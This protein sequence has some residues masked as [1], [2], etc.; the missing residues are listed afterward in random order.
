MSKPFLLC[1]DDERI[2]L[3]SLRV[4]LRR[5]VGGEFQIETAS[6]GD[7]ALE[8]V[9]TLVLEGSDLVMII[10]DENMPGM[11]GHELLTAVR[12][13]SPETHLVLLTGYSDLE[14]VQKAVNVAGLY[15]YMNKPWKIDELVFTIR[16]AYRNRRQGQTIREQKGRIAR[17]TKSMIFALETA[18]QNSDEDTMSHIERV[19]AYSAALAE[20]L[21]KDSI[22]VERIRLYSGLHDIGKVGVACQLLHSPDKFTDAEREIQKQH[23]RYG[24]Q[25]LSTEGIDEMASNIALY[26]HER[27]DSKGYLMGV[28]GEAIPLE[29]RIVALTDV[30]DALSSRRSYKEALPFDE[31]WT[32]V[33]DMSG[34]W[35]DPQLVTSFSG[36]KS[37]VLQIK[38]S[39]DSN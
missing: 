12:E 8:V 1:V 2:L 39:I 35:F 28:Q 3:E 16:Q 26:H 24:F 32:Q 4:E 18:N 11:K 27:W 19:S 36:I 29:A 31:A 38:D 34:S 20:S 23:V 17:L 9:R 10:S 33:L 7:E 6:S 5:E 22:W 21:G 25:I 13:L 30:F 14:A 15:R 37:E